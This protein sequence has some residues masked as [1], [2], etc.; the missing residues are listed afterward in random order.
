ML[1][2]ILSLVFWLAVLGVFAWAFVLLL[3][4]AQLEAEPRSVSGYMMFMGISR[5]LLV[6]WLST[7]TLL[8]IFTGRKPWHW[9]RK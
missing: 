3:A 4:W 8:W 5:F 1:N 2:R 9:L 6:G 7:F